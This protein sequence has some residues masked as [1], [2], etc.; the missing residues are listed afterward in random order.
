LTP[1]SQEQQHFLQDSIASFPAGSVI[2]LNEHPLLVNINLFELKQAILES[3]YLN[4]QEKAF[5]LADYKPFSLIEG[6]IVVPVMAK[7]MKTN[8]YTHVKVQGGPGYMLSIIETRNHFPLEPAFAATVHKSQ[9]RTL[10]KVIL[11]LS[12]RN[13]AR[14]NLSYEALYVALS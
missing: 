8:Q 5:V 6:E 11:A 2:T 4:K 3:T 14:C 9:G 10:N 12:Y 1:S 13:A 7:Q